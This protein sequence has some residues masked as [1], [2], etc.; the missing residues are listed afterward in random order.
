MSHSTDPSHDDPTPLEESSFDHILF[1]DQ[2]LTES[3]S[4]AK[5]LIARD[6]AEVPMRNKMQLFATIARLIDND[7]NFVVCNSAL[8][9]ELW[10]PADIA[11]RV[12]SFMAMESPLI[13]S[14][15]TLGAEEERN[16]VM[17]AARRVADDLTAGW[18]PTGISGLEMQPAL[19][20]EYMQ[21]APSAPSFQPPLPGV[22]SAEFICSNPRCTFRS[23]NLAD[24]ILHTTQR[25]NPE[26][27]L[28][29]VSNHPVRVVMMP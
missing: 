15:K 25:T 26:G 11:T 5:E 7:I 9:P 23:T 1:P 14:I 2:P 6:M 28:R 12:S 18:R 24:A 13:R 19:P 3:P 21:P 17:T 22:E 16:R 10:V 20:E 8:G 4:H 27:F 29:P